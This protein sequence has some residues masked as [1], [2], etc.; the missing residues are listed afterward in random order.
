MRTLSLLSLLFLSCISVVFAAPAKVGPRDGLVVESLPPL[1]TPQI[2]AVEKMPDTAF[3]A[4]LEKMGD[5]ASAQLAWQRIAYEA[6]GPERE[7]ALFQVL[8]LQSLQGQQQAV[9]GTMRVLEGD[10]PRTPRAPEALYYL[11]EAQTGAHKQET[12]TTLAGM[13][14]QSP[15]SQ[16]AL[17][18]DVWQQLNT[19]GKITQNYNLPQALKIEGRLKLLQQEGKT[20]AATAMAFGLV[21]GGGHFYLHQYLQGAVMLLGW[22]LFGLAFLSACRHRHYAY[23]LVFVWPFAALWA[24]SPGA[25]AG[26][27]HQQEKDATTRAI[28]NWND[29]A[30]PPLPQPGEGIPEEAEA[31]PVP[32]TP[33]VS[34]TTVPTSTTVPATVSTTAPLASPSQ[35]VTNTAP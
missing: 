22:A 24:T 16:A 9:L 12:L 6:N 21:P 8:R 20:R 33:T 17:M 15:W 26:V 19:T 4:Q 30:P 14:P 25:A 23:A 28:A 5:L 18:R 10:F 3:P 32:A 11:S 35:V 27:A 31:T 29:V 7:K 1:A 2:A 34:G 13:Y